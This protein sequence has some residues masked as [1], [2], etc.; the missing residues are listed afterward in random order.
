MKLK[1]PNNVCN[2]EWNYKGKAKFYTSCPRCRFN[3]KIKEIKDD[4]KKL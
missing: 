3:V 4:K 1:C 2:Y